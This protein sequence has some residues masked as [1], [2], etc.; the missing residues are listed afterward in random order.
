M[1]E[2]FQREY[3]AFEVA[4]VQLEAGVAHRQIRTKV[5][6]KDKREREQKVKTLADELANGTFSHTFQQLDTVLF[7]LIFN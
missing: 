2:L 5:I 3:A 4:I 6:Q 7:P 1:L